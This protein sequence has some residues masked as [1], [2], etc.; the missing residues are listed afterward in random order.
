MFTFYK[1]C[2]LKWEGIGNWLIEMLALDTLAFSI[3][4]LECSKDRKV[5]NL[6]CNR[7]NITCVI[8]IW[9]SDQLIVSKHSHNTSKSS[10]NDA[11]LGTS[12]SGAI[13]KPS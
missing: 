6:Q 4:S 3:G 8:Y 13:F 5:N 1:E 12:A 11:L 9:A 10:R 7:S 2:F